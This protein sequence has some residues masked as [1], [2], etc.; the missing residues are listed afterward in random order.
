MPWNQKKLRWD[1]LLHSY[2]RIHSCLI[3]TK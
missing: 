3:K 1:K 2:T